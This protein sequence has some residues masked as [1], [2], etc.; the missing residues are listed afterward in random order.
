MTK[1]SQETCF[2]CTAFVLVVIKSAEVN[3]QSVQSFH[4]GPLW[5]PVIMTSVHFAIEVAG[6]EATIAPKSVKS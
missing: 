2:D 4:F 5:K 1:S 6:A 3:A